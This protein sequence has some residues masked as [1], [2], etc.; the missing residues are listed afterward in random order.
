MQALRKTSRSRQP[1]GV[2]GRVSAALHQRSG[3]ER[4]AWI[5]RTRSRQGSIGFDAINGLIQVAFDIAVRSLLPEVS[6]HDAHILCQLLLYI[7][8]PGLDV[9]ILV[10]VGDGV[11]RS[12]PAG[13]LIGV[14]EAHVW[15]LRRRRKKTQEWRRAVL[16]QG[17]YLPYQSEWRKRCGAPFCRY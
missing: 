16:G 6:N 13:S 12:D 10:I 8:V 3:A 9:V 11:R 14:R 5:D 7:E 15:Y 17:N 4:H 2:I 1:Q